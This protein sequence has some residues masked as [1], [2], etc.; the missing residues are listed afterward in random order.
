MD[1]HPEDEPALVHAYFW[2]LPL[3][4]LKYRYRLA[5]LKYA[6]VGIS[7]AT[8]VVIKRELDVFIC[9][10]FIGSAYHVSVE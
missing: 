2:I 8:Q 9:N 7:G 10:E 6:Y 4:E 3:G 5:L 1:S